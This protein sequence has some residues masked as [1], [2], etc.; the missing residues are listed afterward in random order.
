MGKGNSMGKGKSSKTKVLLLIF[1]TSILPALCGGVVMTYFGVREIYLARESMTWPS[2]EGTITRS[3][4]K[5]RTG[6]GSGT[7]YDAHIVYQFAVDGQ[8]RLGNEVAFGVQGATPA[9]IRTLLNRYPT[10]K[11]V[12]VYYRASAPDSSILEPGLEHGQFWALPGIGLFIVLVMSSVTIYVPWT[13]SR[14]KKQ[15]RRGRE[16][17]RGFSY[18]NPPRSI[19]LQRDGQ[20]FEMTLR[21]NRLR[22]LI[23]IVAVMLAPILFIYIGFVLDEGLALVGVLGVILL[24]AFLIYFTLE[25][26]ATE[27]IRVETDKIEIRRFKLRSEVSKHILP[28][29]D[30]RKVIVSQKANKLW[31]VEIKARNEDEGICIDV[32]SR[33]WISFEAAQWIRKCILKVR[34]TARRGKGR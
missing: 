3:Q 27:T 9:S 26:S 22:L 25:I 4:T 21:K 16:P 2:T 29:S 1:V 5:V 10:G 32:G 18:K 11:T 17:S 13:L 7:Y 33:S 34:A 28:M 31:F 6:G 8:T 20:A 23:Q 15:S 24:V 14:Q 19:K 12:N 30:I